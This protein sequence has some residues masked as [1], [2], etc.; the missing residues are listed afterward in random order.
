MNCIQ[1][2][3]ATAP[4]RTKAAA[5]TLVIKR[6][7]NHFSHL[8]PWEEKTV[9]QY[10][11][12]MTDSQPESI[13]CSA[14]PLDL[15]FHPQ[16][17]HIVAAALVDGTLEVHDFSP[18]DDDDDD[19]E[20]DT[21]VSSIPIKNGL[22]DG[23]NKKSSCRAVLFSDDGSQIFTGTNEGDVCMLDTERACNLSSTL[24]SCILSRLSTGN[25]G[26]PA[27]AL[28]QLPSEA[29]N[30]LVTGDEQGGV[31]LWDARSARQ[32][33]ILWWN[34][35]EDYISDFDYHNNTLLASS[36]DC[37]LSVMDLRMAT[38]DR[39]KKHEAFRKSDDQVD[40]LLSVKVIKNGKKVVC[41]TQEGVLAVWSW[42]T[43]GDV[44]DRFPGHPASIDAMLKVDEDTLLTGSSDGLVR[45]IQIHPDK[46]L[47]VLGDHD[48]YPIEKLQFN[49]TR[50]VVGSV[51][52]NPVI[53]LWDARVLHEDLDESD[54]D[55]VQ[56]DVKGI[57][58]E[59]VTAVASMP[60]APGHGSDDEWDSTEDD[61][62]SDID[63][64]SDDSSTDG[65]DYMH[66]KKPKRLKTANEKFFEDL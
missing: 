46:L 55:E 5:D 53:R 54:D 14:Q 31:S 35:H 17:E 44:S 50:S 37:T 9:T 7:H 34:E 16:R 22:S 2:S 1:P 26:V 33:P 27:H 63:D 47:G 45:L 40:E 8:L 28:Y 49:S 51:S 6:H 10:S 36:A 59:K 32:K 23:N 13:E 15:S 38:A 60:N 43:W 3:V 30:L 11:I 41:G 62:G 20:H 4:Q 21:I 18:N 66:A 65:E 48:G 61:M 52:H 12:T 19:D 25:D 64:D 58:N 29:G 24:D 42:G 56:G 57:A 39:S